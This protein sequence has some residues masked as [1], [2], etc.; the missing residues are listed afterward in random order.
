[1]SD[2]KR[3]YHEEG[4]KDASE[5]KYNSPGGILVISPLEDIV[6]YS[7]GHGSTRGQIDGAQNEYNP[8]PLDNP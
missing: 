4:Q 5:G 2:K 3:G 8:P 7:V 1:M 6:E